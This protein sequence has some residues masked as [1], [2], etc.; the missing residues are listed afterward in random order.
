[1]ALIL[2]HRG[3]SSYAPDNTEA[4]FRLAMEMG[5]DGVETDVHLTAD[6]VPVMQHN[7]DICKNSNGHGNVEKMT[8]EELLKY[9]FGSWKGEQFAGQKILTLDEF[10][11]LAEELD[12]KFI[13]IELKFPEKKPSN[14]VKVTLDLVK[15]HNL[16][17]R[18]M[19]SSFD[20]DLIRETQELCPEIITG[21]LYDE[22]EVKVDYIKEILA[23]QV[24]YIE[25]LGADFANPHFSYLLDPELVDRFTAKGIGVCVWT[26]DKPYVIRTCMER[27]VKAIVSNKP[28]VAVKA[29][30]KYSDAKA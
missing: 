9:D 29:V 16:V 6:G 26:V 7:Y 4:A 1:M 10:L 25:N 23:D 18:V 2:G 22:D 19:I 15:K 3:A 28:D 21:A 27:G 12:M 30:T 13:D 8:Y 14:I 11:T 24:S 5:A 17:D 20:H